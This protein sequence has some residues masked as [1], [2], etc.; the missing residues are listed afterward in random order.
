MG[1]VMTRSITSLFGLLLALVALDAEA[2]TVTYSDFVSLD[3]ISQSQMDQN[4]ADVEAAVT[5]LEDGTDSL[6][7][8][9]VLLG[10]SIADGAHLTTAGVGDA[11]WDDG[12]DTSI[13]WLWSLFS[14]ANPTL[15]ITDGVFTF[16]GDVIATG[17]I[18][19]SVKTASPGNQLI[20]PANDGITGTAPSCAANGAGTDSFR[21]LD[22]TNSS[23]ETWVACH[24]TAEIFDF[25]N[26]VSPLPN[27]GT[28]TP[29]FPEVPSGQ[30]DSSVTTTATGASGT[31]IVTWGF[32][33][34]PFGEPGFAPVTTGGLSVTPIAGTDLITWHVC[35]PTAGALDPGTVFIN[36]R[37]M[38]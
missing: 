16:G 26:S 15:T 13:V 37:I 5:A 2:L 17:T 3:V 31:D 12:T 1:S 20:V 11:T 18:A 25:T 28:I 33:T 36:W 6:A 14:G 29:N 34:S 32:F 8:L 19:P 24:G 4:F 23:V 35:N 38:K 10:S 27:S 22:K 21:I 7:S 9:N 30:C